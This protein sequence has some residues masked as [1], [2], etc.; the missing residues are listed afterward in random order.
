VNVYTV[1][2]IKAGHADHLYMF[3]TDME[4]RRSFGEIAVD[5]KIKIGQYPEDF[6]LFKVGVWDGEKMEL[7]P[8]TPVCIAK[9]IEFHI[10][11]KNN[12]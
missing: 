8:L 7:M 10:G 1:L 2:D 6:A 3:R 4:A 5:S 12:G 9:A 11:D